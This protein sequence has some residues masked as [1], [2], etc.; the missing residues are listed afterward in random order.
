MTNFAVN[1]DRNTI[2]RLQR[3]FVLTEPYQAMFQSDKGLATASR[4]DIAGG[5]SGIAA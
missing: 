5:V 3:G 4:S 1:W 2:Q